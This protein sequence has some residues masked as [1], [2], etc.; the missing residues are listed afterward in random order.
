MPLEASR[1]IKV[2]RGGKSTPTLSILVYKDKLIT[3]F[4]RGGGF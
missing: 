4:L 2:E 3:F 1:K